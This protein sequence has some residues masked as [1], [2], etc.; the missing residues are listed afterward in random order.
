MFPSKVLFIFLYT[1]FFLQINAFLLRVE[2]V[3]SSFCRES[4]P[5]TRVR[6]F[7]YVANIAI[8]MHE[9]VRALY[10]EFWMYP[11]EDTRAQVPLST[12]HYGCITRGSRRVDRWQHWHASWIVT[13]TCP[14]SKNYPPS[15]QAISSI[16]KLETSLF[17]QWFVS[18]WNWILFQSSQWLKTV[19]PKAHSNFDDHQP[20]QCQP[21]CRTKSFNGCR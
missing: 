8:S 4:E 20:A 7:V 17:W 11:R 21:L 18:R 3:R 6:R 9:R 12:M 10:G 15:K 1:P 14:Y 5:P 19:R 13:Q 16:D 2:R